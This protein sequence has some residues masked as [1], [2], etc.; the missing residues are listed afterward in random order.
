MFSVNNFNLL[1]TMKLEQSFTKHNLCLG[2]LLLKTPWIE[3]CPQR[4]NLC[5]QHSS[6]SQSFIFSQSANYIYP[7]WHFFV[8]II[9]T[10]YT[11]ASAYEKSQIRQDLNFW[12]QTY[13]SGNFPAE[14]QWPHFSSWQSSMYRLNWSQLSSTIWLSNCILFNMHSLL[15]DILTFKV[16]LL[17]SATCFEKNN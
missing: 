3:N 1:M 6:F 12:I 2:Q 9:S 10:K 17:C 7:K 16:F 15:V 13:V 5:E 14:L 4:I 8:D 11:T